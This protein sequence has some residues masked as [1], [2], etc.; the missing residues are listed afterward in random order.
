MGK[1]KEIHKGKVA[2]IAGGGSG[3]GKEI[4]LYLA[5]KGAVVIIADV[6]IDSANDVLKEIKAI[7]SEC[8]AKQVDV[9]IKED[10]HSLITSVK[11]QFGKID[12][13]INSAGIGLD[14][15]F[16]DVTMKSFKHVIDVNL[17]GVIYGTYFAY[18][19]MISQGFGQ[20]VNVSSLAGLLPG[21]LM[22]SYVASKQGVTGFTLSL[23]AE[24]N[25]YGIK[26]NALCPG[27]IE[28]PIH[29]KT[30]K[31]SEYLKKEQNQRN[32]KHFPTANKC[33]GTMMRGIEKNKAI[34]V[35]PRLHK[36]FWILYRVFPSLI[37]L[38]WSKIIKQLKDN[39]KNNVA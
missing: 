20:I 33:I 29:D 6:N 18:Q 30:E 5:R 22:T 21:G 36:A 34:I 16:K 37:P 12:L 39:S 4:C 38:A 2:I 23:R 19:I 1:S 15:E 26:V 17:W 35:V 7:G 11:D 28:T 14:G 24:A 10:V 27:F 25:L 3:I 8:I 32:K 9:T 13:L 31:V